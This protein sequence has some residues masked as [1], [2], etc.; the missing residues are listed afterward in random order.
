[1]SG[2]TDFEPT[3]DINSSVRPA[4]RDTVPSAP[5]DV[6]ECP[7]TLLLQIKL[8]KVYMVLRLNPEDMFLQRGRLD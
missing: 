2:Q 3:G 5:K 1:M 4:G 6:S 8:L 7:K